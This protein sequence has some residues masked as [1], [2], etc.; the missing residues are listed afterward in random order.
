MKTEIGTVILVR[1]YD[2]T[3]WLPYVA[4]VVGERKDSDYDIEIDIDGT[5]DYIKENSIICVIGKT[6]ETIEL[7]KRK[8]E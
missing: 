8:K 7:A 3:V 4:L 1:P 6:P 2:E 5:T